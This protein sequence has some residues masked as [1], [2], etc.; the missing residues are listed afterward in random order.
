MKAISRNRP[1][2]ALTVSLN[3]ADCS[4][5]AS[6][7]TTSARA[8]GPWVLPDDRAQE[9]MAVAESAAE[10]HEQDAMRDQRADHGNEQHRDRGEPWRRPVQRVSDGRQH[11]CT[12]GHVA[13]PCRVAMSRGRVTGPG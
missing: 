10:N 4:A 6:A 11:R 9:R 13:W 7:N 12:I 2:E 3:G 5:A 8:S 1:N